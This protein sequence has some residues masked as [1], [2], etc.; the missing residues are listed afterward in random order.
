MRSFLISA[1]LLASA[2]VASP[3]KASVLENDN[4]LLGRDYPLLQERS[5]VKPGRII[6]GRSDKAERDSLYASQ[7]NLVERAISDIHRAEGL[8]K[9]DVEKRELFRRQL[10]TIP[11]GLGPRANSSICREAV[12]SQGFTLPRDGYANCNQNIGS[13]QVKCRNGFTLR[14]GVC[15]QNVGNCAPGLCPPNPRNGIFTCP[16][17]RSCNLVCLYGQTP[18]EDGLSCINTKFD[19]NNCGGEGIVCPPS[20][21]NVGTVSC[22]NNRC[23]IRCPTGTRTRYSSTGVYFCA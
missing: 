11:C 7:L 14:N 15:I 16:F 1:A 6:S 20:Y 12:T 9:R 18:S 10:N 17:G 5:V 19:S 3:L 4:A 21:N 22:F 2:A 23:S 13:C 8:T